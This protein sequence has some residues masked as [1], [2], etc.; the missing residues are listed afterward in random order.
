MD[1]ELDRLSQLV[2]DLLKL[3]RLDNKQDLEQKPTELS[4]LVSKI[5]KALAFLA[6]E[7]GVRVE[8]E[9]LPAAVIWADENR[10]HGALLNIVD[11]AIKYAQSVVRVSMVTGEQ[12]EI[13]VEDDGPGIPEAA[14]NRLFERFY[15]LDQ[16]RARHNG[17]SGLGLAIAWEII[18]RHRGSI[19]V[20]SE[21]GKGTLVVVELPLKQIVF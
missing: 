11:N 19:Q 6:E 14:R 20:I 9:A 5:V 16:A 2:E 3:A 1:K 15:R 4:E 12:V 13:R 17:G 8:V 10:L 18:S 7:R 21:E